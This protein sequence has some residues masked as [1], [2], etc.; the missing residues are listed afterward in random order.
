VEAKS[1]FRPRDEREAAESLRLG[2]GRLCLPAYALILIRVNQR[3]SAASN[4]NARDEGGTRRSDWSGRGHRDGAR[5]RSRGRPRYGL[6]RGAIRRRS[7]IP[8]LPKPR[9]SRAG[10]LARVPPAG[11]AIG[12][13]RTATVVDGSVRVRFGTWPSS[14]QGDALSPSRGPVRRRF[15]LGKH[16]LP[17][18]ASEIDLRRLCRFHGVSL[19]LYEISQ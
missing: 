6:A 18:P 5:T 17:K 2:L 11:C 12:C 4:G 19:H 13:W 10:N 1:R 9:R 14:Q 16:P 7:A 15:A 3:L 8:I